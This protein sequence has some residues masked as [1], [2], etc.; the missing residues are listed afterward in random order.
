MH[1]GCELFTANPSMC[2]YK[3]T[4]ADGVS[5]VEKCCACGGGR[6]VTAK[7]VDEE[8]PD[9][10][11]ATTSFALTTTYTFSHCRDGV[12]HGHL[13]IGQH[14]TEY[15]HATCFLFTQHTNLCNGGYYWPEVGT[16]K[17]LCCACGGGSPWPPA[18]T[19][20][21]PPLPEPVFGPTPEAEPCEHSTTTAPRATIPPHFI[22][23][24]PTTTTTTPCYEE[25]T[26]P[27]AYEAPVLPPVVVT[28]T[29]VPTTSTWTFA[30]CTDLPHQGPLLNKDGVVVV[31]GPVTCWFF[32]QDTSR[33]GRGLYWE[34]YGDSDDVCCACGGGSTK[35]HEPPPAPPE[36]PPPCVHHFPIEQ[37]VVTYPDC[38]DRSVYGMI[39]LADEYNE[40]GHV[41]CNYFSLHKDLCRQGYHWAKLGTTE[42]MCCACG[43]GDPLSGSANS[44]ASLDSTESAGTAIVASAYDYKVVK[45]SNEFC[46]DPHYIHHAKQAS[47]LVGE[48]QPEADESLALSAAN[49][50]ICKEKCDADPNC[51]YIS[52]WNSGRCHLTHSCTSRTA[53]ETD[54]I[55]ILQ[56]DEHANS[57][58]PLKVTRTPVTKATPLPTP[59]A[60]PT[61]VVP[62]PATVVAPLTP[63]PTPTATPT[64][65]VPTPATVVAP[66]T[67]L[68]PL[69][70][71]TAT[72]T[73]VV[74]TP[75][76][77]VAPLTPSPTPT[78]TPTG[79]EAWKQKVLDQ[80]NKFRCMHDAP[81]VAWSE[82]VAKSAASFIALQTNLQHS[83]SY[84]LPPPAGPAGENLAW[85]SPSIDTQMAVAD[86]YD[87]SVDCTGGA[88]G[89]QD[90]CKT[91]VNGKVTGHFTA[92]IW[93]GVTHIGCAINTA[94]TILICRYWSGNTKGPQTANMGGQYVA[95]V[96]PQV[97]SSDI[98][99]PTHPSGEHTTIGLALT[100]S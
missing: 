11:P 91:G 81:S 73:A 40:L 34:G 68:T 52:V 37:T 57:G 9:K 12:V 86:W 75:A 79:L 8:L 35:P 53:H 36:A 46:N 32:M 96:K 70:T 16:A 77:V 45:R 55:T 56:K 98:C 20:E 69:P 90:G 4:W 63:S 6:P 97:K 31:Q 27:C 44:D 64:V 21:P 47:L 41:D 23:K 49:L 43:G 50:Q 54:D 95:N 28:T 10:E 3:Y 62:T 65:V 87:E 71:P 66:L 60:T 26:T 39:K 13:K 18:T 85:R 38:K 78:A 58:Q 14:Y 92:M 72:P 33:C 19:E 42:D 99:H 25:T 89:F 74:P 5:A 80:H 7:I 22:S 93:K 67:P 94:N 29:E 88:S 84:N 100:T 48:L 83:D 82:E 76:T 30:H 1:A 2:S 61:A 24:T 59:T 51:A 17:H 15:G